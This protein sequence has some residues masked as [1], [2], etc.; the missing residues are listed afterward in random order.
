MEFWQDDP[1]ASRDLCRRTWV[2][3][4]DMGAAYPADRLEPAIQTET[5]PAA[6]Q[7]GDDQVSET[8][9]LR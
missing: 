1:M 8:P 4:L 3:G 6:P 5:L 7:P 9:L 2:L